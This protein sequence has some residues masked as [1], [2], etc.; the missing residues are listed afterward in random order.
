MGDFTNELDSGDY[1]KE[2]VS[3]KKYCYETKNG[4][5][6]CKVRG[7]TLNSQGQQGFNFHSIKDYVLN[8]ITNPVNES[9]VIETRNPNK[10]VRD[11]KEK[12][13]YTK[14]E[15]KN[16]RL[17]FDKCVLDYDTLQSYPCGHS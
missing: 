15:C 4:K 1:I 11:A 2:F 3:A 6:R 12:H 8:E 10:I 5:Q 16:Y 7:F 14:K 17:V 13:I 9:H